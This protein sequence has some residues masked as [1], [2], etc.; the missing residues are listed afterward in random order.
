MGM[1]LLSKMIFW[2]NSSYRNDSYKKLVFEIV[3]KYNPYNRDDSCAYICKE[4]NWC[5]IP[6][7]GMILAF[8]VCYRASGDIIPIMGMIL[9]QKHRE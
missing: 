8:A 4:G 9:T 1:I 3:P 7:L 6:I 5:I 2:Y